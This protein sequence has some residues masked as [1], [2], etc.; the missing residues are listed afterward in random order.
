MEEYGEN[1]PELMP[2]TSRRSIV[3]DEIYGLKPDWLENDLISAT[4]KS[5]VGAT[6]LGGARELFNPEDVSGLLNYVAKHPEEMNHAF[7][8]FMQYDE[9]ATAGG[10]AGF[11]VYMGI[12][13]YNTAKY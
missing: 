7:D 6:S 10:L 9:L 12:E 1:W 13:A 8:L 3:R 5:L 4:V 11:A 2:D